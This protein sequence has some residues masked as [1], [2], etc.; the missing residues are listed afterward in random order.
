MAKNFQEVQVAA[1]QYIKVIPLQYHVCH[2]FVLPYYGSQ[3]Q[4]SGAF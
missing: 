2:D 1:S 3:R 4:Y